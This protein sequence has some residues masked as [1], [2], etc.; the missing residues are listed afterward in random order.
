MNLFTPAIAALLIASIGYDYVPW[1]GNTLLALWLW[2]FGA[3]V[4]SFMN[5]VIFRVPAGMSVAYPGSKC[6]KCLKHIAWCDNIPVISWLCLRA[7]CRYCALPISSRYPTI[8]AIVAIVFLVLAFV[9]PVTRGAN[10]P[11]FGDFFYYATD[12]SMWVMYGY[13]TLLLCV[14]ICAT[15]IRYDR[16]RTPMRLGFISDFNV[17]SI[18]P[19]A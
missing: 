10:L 13:H 16:Q 6:P 8:E 11:K 19:V 18:C 1:W 9:Q 4:G 17:G 2:S 14:L 7:K 12:L 15:M 3:N 5:V